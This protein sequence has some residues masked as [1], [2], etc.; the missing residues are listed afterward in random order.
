M[1]S[2]L[3]VDEAAAFLKIKRTTLYTWAYR[4]QI[5]SQKSRPASYFGKAN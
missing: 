1:N 2:L 4:Q 3:T 5:P